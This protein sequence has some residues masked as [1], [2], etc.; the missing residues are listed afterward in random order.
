MRKMLLTGMLCLLSVTLPLSLTAQNNTKESSFYA[1]VQAEDAVEFQK[2]YPNS[3]SIYATVDGI[4]AVKI[5]EKVAHELHEKVVAH[6]PGYVYM[7]SLEEAVQ[8]IQKA[9]QLKKAK[10]TLTAADFTIDQDALVSQALNLVD[11]L[12]IDA[13]I[14]K[15]VSYGTRYHTTNAAKQSVQ[16]IKSTWESLGTGR[17]DVTVRLVNHTSST[18]PS[19]VMTIKGSTYPDEYVIIG[20]HIDSTN[21][22]N[23]NN[24]PGADD[25]ASGIA[26]ITEAARVLMAMG[27]KPART[28]EIMAYAAEEVGLRGSKEIAKDYRARNVNVLAATQFDMTN[29]KGS[30]QDIF[31]INDT[32]TTPLLNTYLMQL[33]DHYN[34]SGPHKLV[35]STTK[36]NYGCSD[37]ASWKAEGY[38]AAFPFESA[39]NTSS[40]YIHTAND[41]HENAPVPQSVHAAKFAK[42]AVEFLIEVAKGA[43]APPA[44]S[45][46]AGLGASSISTTGATLN[47]NTVSQATSYAIN[48]R[49]VGGAWVSTTSTTNAKVLTGLT[50]NTNYE[51]QV[52]SVCSGGSQSAFSGIATFKTST[53]NPVT[54]CTAKG[55][56]AAYEWIANVTVG[57][58]T[59]TTVGNGGYG[60]F[61]SQ[62]VT[63]TRGNTYNLSLKPGFSGSTYQ[64]YWKIW[65]DYNSDGD[66]TDAGEQ[67]FDGGGFSTTQVTGSFNVPSTTPLVSTRM[68]VI[69]RYRAVPTPCGNFNYGEVE[70]YTVNIIG[71]SAASSV[72]EDTEKG[73]TFEVYPNPP[74]EGT[75]L[76]TL[77]IQEGFSEKAVVKIMTLEGLTVKSFTIEN[78]T[79]KF[80]PRELPKGKTYI[81]LVESGGKYWTKSF[82]NQ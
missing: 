6:G 27:F 5:T 59:N 76:V 43:G 10:A 7:S 2:L 22:S 55:N 73:L 47:W 41:I 3:V 49:T 54:Y 8:S 79:T 66:F 20:G 51:F 25:D 9:T 68:R 15:L 14:K 63:L 39:M 61:T 12:K 19:A 24:A 64:E 52:R 74:E 45:I 38:N 58:L 81:I 75:D 78:S 72:T 65:I 44:C 56:N 32:Y 16:D 46:P 57:S 80:N 23:N 4:S 36:C 18:M 17:S 31:I 69:M 33:M 53:V 67:V 42:L 77:N 13:T 82:N 11:N 71:S 30:P 40:P 1:T 37:H 29:Y 50:A 28:I 48:Y 62:S 34:A 21:P 60:D 35:Y 26:T 70:D